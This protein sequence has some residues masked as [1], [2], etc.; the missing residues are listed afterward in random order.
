MRSGS[1]RG[2]AQRNSHF[3]LDAHIDTTAA[4]GRAEVVMPVGAVKGV[5]RFEKKRCPRHTGQ[6]IP[7]V[8]NPTG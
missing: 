6:F 7:M 1:C 3:V 4:H 2:R 8:D 5:S